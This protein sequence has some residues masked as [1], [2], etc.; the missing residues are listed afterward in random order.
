MIRLQRWESGPYFAA[1]S[2]HITDMR[3]EIVKICPRSPTVSQSNTQ[4]RQA[5]SQ[6]RARR[7]GN[8]FAALRL[9]RAHDYPGRYRTDLI[10]A[11]KILIYSPFGMPQKSRQG[12]H[13]GDHG[14]PLASPAVP[15]RS[16]HCPI[17]RPRS[18]LSARYLG[19]PEKFTGNPGR[20]AHWRPDPPAHSHRGARLAA[21]AARSM[22]T[23]KSVSPSG[24]ATRRTP[25][26]RCAN[27]FAMPRQ[28]W[29][30]LL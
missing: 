12:R 28:I 8:L 27:T 19:K 30:T 29:T 18:E 23:T 25:N 21:S 16:R 3:V 17:Q 22:N 4:V 13:S 5:P 6:A 1:F 15:A 14:H 24:T 2:L 10:R 20:R 26:D 7:P 9:F 11:E